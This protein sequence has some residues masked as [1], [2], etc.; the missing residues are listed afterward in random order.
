MTLQAIFFDLDGTLADTERQNGE[1]VARVLGAR[2]RA[3]TDE[4]RDFVIGHGWREI[5]D[6]LVAHG[7]IELTFEELTGLASDERAKLVAEEGLDVLPGAVEL[8]RRVATRYRTAV[9]SGSTRD[10]VDQCLRALG[11]RDCFPWFVAAEDAPRGKPSPDGYLMAAAR[12]DV[13]PGACLAVEDSTAGIRAARA[14]GMR[15]VAVRAGNFA[16]QPQEEASLV[17]DTLRDLD[18][19]L[20]AQIAEGAYLR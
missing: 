15:C 12:Y 9:V 8:V 19:A 6:H 3:V 13:P 1:A 4:E 20:L 2:G 14:A 11:V 16:A 10:E 18:D 5:Y 17:V 7:G